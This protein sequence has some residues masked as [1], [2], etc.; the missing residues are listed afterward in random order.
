MVYINECIDVNT[1]L[2]KK[3]FK[4]MSCFKQLVWVGYISFQEI[5]YS[6][7]LQVVSRF[8]ISN[9]CFVLSVK[10]CNTFDACWD[11]RK[12]LKSS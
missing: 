3:T 8:I 4:S 10:D 6:G 12:S 9:K 7:M 2:K 1:A 5:S 11:E